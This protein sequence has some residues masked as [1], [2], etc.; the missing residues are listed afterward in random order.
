MVAPGGGDGC[1]GLAAGFDGMTAQ[2]KT[3]SMQ[4][5]LENRVQLD[6]RL[7][8]ILL[9]RSCDSSDGDEE[10]MGGPIDLAAR[11]A[12][13]RDTGRDGSDTEDWLAYV[14]GGNVRGVV[15]LTR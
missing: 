12:D 1:G 2:S 10:K 13:E 5:G 8:Q 9:P 7:K 3:A 15:T 6:F 11:D 4:L 14:P